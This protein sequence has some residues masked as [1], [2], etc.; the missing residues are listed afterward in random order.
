MRSSGGRAIYVAT[1]AA[2]DTFGVVSALRGTPRT[3]TVEAVTPVRLRALSAGAVEHIA[4]ELPSLRATLDDWVAQHD[5]Q[6]LADLAKD[7]D[8]EQLPDSAARDDGQVGAP[9][10]DVDL[11]TVD[12]LSADS[13]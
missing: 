12:A 3:T 8:Q 4:A 6:H 10:P 13:G 1:L 7:T 9:Q 5:Y 2:G 11:A